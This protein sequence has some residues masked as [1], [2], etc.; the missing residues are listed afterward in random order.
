MKITKKSKIILYVLATFL[1]L[2]TYS[3]L[4]TK[5]IKVTTINI[6]SHD[7]PNTFDGKRIVFVSDIHHG[8]NLSIDRVK[9]LVLQINNLQP[10]I[11]ILG[12]DYVSREEKY[13]VPVF[14]E[15][16]K[17]KSKFGVYAVLGNHD[18]FVNGDLTKKML[19]RNGIKLCNN[20]SYWIK[21]QH[22]RIKIGGV[23]D[24][25]GSKQEIDSTITDV[26]K[27]N[28]CILISHRPEYMKN[29]NTQ[30]VDLTLSGHTHGGQVT[31]LGLWA[32]I[33]PSDNGL[34]AA[35]THTKDSQKYSYGLIHPKPTTL[36]YITSGIGTRSPHLRFFR[37]PEIVIFELKRK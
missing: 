34:W 33:L 17:L 36:G 32:P 10:D 3:Y 27:N 25:D 18:Y 26:H 22:D 23:D 30:L 8:A 15:L 37:R 31:F 9:K 12:G 7:I 35:L 4:E 19:L 24:P 1:I 11:I 13:I 2:L 16:G 14:A 29:M 28:F 20:K 5:W 21:I 6:E